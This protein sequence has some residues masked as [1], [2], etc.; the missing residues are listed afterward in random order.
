[1][2]VPLAGG[3]PRALAGGVNLGGAIATDGTSLYWSTTTAPLVADQEWIMTAP[4][5]GGTPVKLASATA[6]PAF[7]V[8]SS[9]VY[10]IDGTG[11]PLVTVPRTGGTPVTL[12]AAPVWAFVVDDAHL[13]WG[14][15]SNLSC[16]PLAATPAR[17][18]APSAAPAALDASNVYFTQFD[19][20]PA[21]GNSVYE[22]PI[23]G[24]A[25]AA[26]AHGQSGSGFLAVDATSVYWVNDGGEVMKAAK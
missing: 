7:A 11:G 15:G 6:T 5:G 8:N 17:V 20:A 12:V 22:A 25:P 4:V 23:A 2:A 9:N 26:L 18:V 1:M 13:C 21:F 24:G 19:G 10:W 14:D 3:T 16:G